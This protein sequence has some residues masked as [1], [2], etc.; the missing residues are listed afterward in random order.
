[1][2]NSNDELITKDDVYGIISGF[3]EFIDE[4]VAQSICERVKIIPSVTA[5]GPSID[6]CPKCGKPKETLTIIPVTG[7]PYNPEEYGDKTTTVRMANIRLGI[8]CKC[9][10][11]GMIHKN[12]LDAPDS[13]R[14]LEALHSRVVD[15]WN[16][17]AAGTHR[18][19]L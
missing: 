10:S 6:Y 19:Q 3:K 1:M 16:E 9:R 4:A 11:V 18:R 17:G 7:E 12:N 5:V 15:M 14:L 8:H 2:T 13:I